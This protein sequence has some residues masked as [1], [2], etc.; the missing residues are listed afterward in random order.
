VKIIRVSTVIADDA[1]GQVSQHNAFHNTL[2][3]YFHGLLSLVPGD[4]ATPVYVV[5]GR[6]VTDALFALMNPAVPP[7]I[8]HLSPRAEDSPTLGQMV[9][10]AFDVF[11]TNEGF[12]RR[13]ILRPIYST[14]EAFEE[15]ADGMDSFGG[16][17]VKQALRSMS[18]FA[19]QLY[20]K[21]EISNRRTRE[22]LAGNAPEP[23]EALIERVA[24]DLV[25][26]RWGRQPTA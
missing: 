19:R 22:V 23:S 16:E 12:R 1:S 13:R 26:T 9:D 25:R 24:L 21:K 14:R 18:P 6:F 15:L 20:V 4:R 2:K 17:V 10:R 8:F 7:G 3:L 11:E 5:T